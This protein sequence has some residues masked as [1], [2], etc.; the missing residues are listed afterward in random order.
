MSNFYSVFKLSEIFDEDINVINKVIREKGISLERGMVPESA[1]D[2][3]RNSLGVKK[4][5]SKPKVAEHDKKPKDKV[6]KRYHPSEMRNYVHR[7][8]QEA[9]INLLQETGED[10]SEVPMGGYVFGG[11]ATILEKDII[12]KYFE[13]DSLEE[14][15]KDFYPL[16]SEEGHNIPDNIW[17]I[18]GAELYRNWNN[19]TKKGIKKLIDKNEDDLSLIYE[20][21]DMNGDLTVS[22]ISFLI[23]LETSKSIRYVPARLERFKWIAN[24]LVLY[25]N[26]D[27]G[28]KEEINDFY[29]QSH[30][31][32]IE[33]SHLLSI[34]DV[35]ERMKEDAENK[36]LKKI[37]DDNSY[38]TAILFALK[39]DN[40]KFDINLKV[41]SSFG[42]IYAS[43]NKMKN[44]KNRKENK[45]NG[46][47]KRIA[48]DIENSRDS[49]NG[50][51]NDI[52]GFIANTLTQEKKH[53]PT[54]YDFFYNNYS[55]R[56]IQYSTFI[57]YAS[58]AFLIEYDNNP[59]YREYGEFLSKIS[60][61]RKPEK[62]DRLQSQSKNGNTCLVDLCKTYPDHISL[63]SELES[64]WNKYKKRLKSEGC[65]IGRPRNDCFSRT[66]IKGMWEFVNKFPGLYE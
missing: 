45:F 62:I 16:Q 39:D 6:S 25:K 47:L 23:E 37:N 18:K 42:R 29:L 31:R 3:I 32:P 19:K 34:N 66:E 21:K 26:L 13:G 58:V 4:T 27:E 12:D 5:K 60:K 49:K 54:T 43:F 48:K 56:G 64:N 59:E 65:W 11:L 14:V 55:G 46:A 63:H 44:F 28:L 50:K 7:D 22:A 2:L 17:L 57:N 40:P 8:Q 51:L 35:F 10:M 41:E 53:K 30:K 52:D 33:F 15:V 1:L 20:T 38:M 24:G 61:E 9:F 36:K